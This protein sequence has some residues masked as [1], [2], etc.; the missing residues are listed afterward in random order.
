M[1]LYT[2]WLGTNNANFNGNLWLTGANTNCFWL[3]WLRSISDCYYYGD[4]TGLNGFLMSSSRLLFSMGVGIMPK[5]FSK[6]H[7]KYKTPYVAIIF[8][9]AITLIAPWLGRTALTWIVDM[10]ST[11]VSIAYFI[12]CLSVLSYL[13]TIN[14]VTR[15]VL[16]IRPLLFWVLLFHLSFTF[17]ISSRITASLSMPSYIALGSWLVI[18]LIFFVVRYPKLKI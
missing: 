1:I 15:M 12:T 6:L 10:S 8:L 3:Y 7:P 14:K 5:A 17:I 16:F 13:V 2:G 18:G 9:V 11:G 4:F